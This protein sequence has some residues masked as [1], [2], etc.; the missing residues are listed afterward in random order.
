MILCLDMFLAGLK[1]TT[2]TLATLFLFLTLNPDWIKKLQ[3]ELDVVVGK[4]RSPTL[5]DMDS[6]PII[7]A[8]LSEV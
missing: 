5:N 3:N 8:F 7:E 2:D 6:C 1:T 4:D